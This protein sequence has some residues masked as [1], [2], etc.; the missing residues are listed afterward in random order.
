MW[1]TERPTLTSCDKAEQNNTVLASP[2]CGH[3]GVRTAHVGCW[4]Q[5]S[6]A[7]CMELCLRIWAAGGTCGSWAPPTVRQPHLIWSGA[8]VAVWHLKSLQLPSKN[9]QSSLHQN[10]ANDL[11]TCD[12]GLPG[13]YLHHTQQRPG[14]QHGMCMPSNGSQLPVELLHHP[15]LPETGFG[16]SVDCPCCTHSLAVCCLL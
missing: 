10:M 16:V 11:K 6:W 3:H 14:H 5:L 9:T 15:L 12:R 13:W 1:G 8:L 2:Y 7:Y 4:W